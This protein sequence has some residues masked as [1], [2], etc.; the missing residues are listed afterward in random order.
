[1]VV[2]ARQ[3]RR[4]RVVHESRANTRHLVRGDGDPYSRTTHRHAEV[5]LTTGDTV[6]DGRTEVGVINRSLGVIRAE[7]DYF[8]TPLAKRRDQQLLEFIPGVIRRQALTITP[9]S[10]SFEMRPT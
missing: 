4:S 5:C 6:A 10:F 7:I 2:F 9:K 3:A 1:M 8:V